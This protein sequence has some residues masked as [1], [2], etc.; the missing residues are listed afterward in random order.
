MNQLKNMALVVVAIFLPAYAGF[1][2]GQK[3][4]FGLVTEAAGCKSG[5]C[6]CGA[7]DG[8]EMIGAGENTVPGAGGETAKVMGPEDLAKAMSVPAKIANPDGDFILVSVIEGGVENQQL[9][10]DLQLVTAQRQQLGSLAEQFDSAPASAVQQRELIAGQ[11][12]Q[13]KNSLEDNLRVMA[14]TYGYS[15]S[16]NYLRVPHLV[17]LVSVVEEDG[18]KKGE[19]VYTFEN[20]ESFDVFQK[21]NAGYTRMKLEM[22]KTAEEASKDDVGAVAEEDAEANKAL[23]KMKAEFMETYRYDPARQYQ[24]VYKKTAFYARSAR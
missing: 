19:V 20:A 17:S 13:V 10:Q 9:T 18:K 7:G 11:L 24:L 16:N 22:E 8:N 4:A 2:V 5:G 3:N 21:K 15:V 12:N 14:R 1:Y 23:E 6:E